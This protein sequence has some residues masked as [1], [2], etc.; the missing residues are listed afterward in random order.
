MP[1]FVSPSFPSHLP[2]PFPPLSANSDP[3]Q[4]TTNRQP[5]VLTGGKRAP[6]HH[7]KRTFSPSPVSHV[8]H[9]ATP[10]PPT[11]VVENRSEQTLAARRIIKDHIMNVGVTNVETTRNMVFAARSARAKYANYLAQQKE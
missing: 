5:G 7:L 11:L 6:S 8:L 4:T 10:A 2:C 9:P 1:P 3:A